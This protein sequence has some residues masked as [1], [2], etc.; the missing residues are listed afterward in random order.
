MTNHEMV[1]ETRRDSNTHLIL[2]IHRPARDSS[3]GLVS[4]GAN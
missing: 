4:G 2:A 1:S 3:S